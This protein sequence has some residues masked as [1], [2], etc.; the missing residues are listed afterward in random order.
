METKVFIETLCLRTIC[1][2]KID[3]I[4][5]LSSASVIAENTYCLSFFIL[6]TFN[7]KNFA[8]L[9]IDE[10]VILILEYLEPS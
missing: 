5:L 9:P 3:N 1:F 2:I 8:A 6:A 4:P 7:L 10:L